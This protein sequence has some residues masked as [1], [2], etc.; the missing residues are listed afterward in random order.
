[1]AFYLDHVSNT[2]L[3]AFARSLLLLIP[4]GRRRRLVALEHLLQHLVV[5]V[6]E[7]DHVPAA[8]LLLSG[9]RGGSTGAAAGGRSIDGRVLREVEHGVGAAHGVG[10]SVVRSGG[11]LG[12]VEGAQPDAHSVAA[13]VA[14]LRRVLAPRPPPHAAV[15][16]R[17]A[18]AV[19]HV[20]AGDMATGV[21]W[22]LLAQLTM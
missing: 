13:R 3:R 9:R 7:L 12:G 16:G 4:R 17:L 19:V 22:L 14:D 11:L 10:G 2:N 1:M 20:S 21:V 8:V 5:E 6:L 15:L 18:S